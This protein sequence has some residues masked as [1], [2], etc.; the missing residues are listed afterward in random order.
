MDSS[1]G[2]LLSTL[3]LMLPLIVVPALVVMRP[4]EQDSGFGGSDLSAAVSEGFPSSE[5]EFASMFDSDADDKPAVASDNSSRRSSSSSNSFDLLDMPFDEFESE[6]IA[7]PETRQAAAPRESSD[8]LNS[9][10]NQPPDR[11]PPG[12]S[13]KRTP[14]LSRW[15]VTRSVWF[16][17]GDPGRVGFAV[18]AP[19]SNGRVLYRFESIGTSDREVIEDV[20]R[21]LDEWRAAA[22]PSRD[23][24][25]D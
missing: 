6:D 5:D 12:R 2:G 16:T 9:R 3:I 20:V 11:Q 23:R 18:F 17:P 1:R 15:G 19:I 14:N 8:A 13:D 7:S 21:Q 4:S 10:R 25:A 22:A 24:R